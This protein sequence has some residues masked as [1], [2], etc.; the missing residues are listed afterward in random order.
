MDM[1][2]IMRLLK[3]E[4]TM[5]TT[6]YIADKLT[7]YLRARTDTCALSLQNEVKWDSLTKEDAQ[8]LGFIEWTTVNGKDLWLIPFWL[9]LAIPNNLPVIDGDTGK[10]F[11][12]N[13]STASTDCRFG[14][15]P[16][17]ILF[18]GNPTCYLDEE[19]IE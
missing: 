19:T 2:K 12:F 9:Y 8:E 18:D 15:L 14:V 6:D 1:M 16:Y 13:R 17:G 7:P 3:W 10:E 11:F 4:M 5:V